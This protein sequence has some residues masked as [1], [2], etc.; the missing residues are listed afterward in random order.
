MF[1]LRFYLNI[2]RISNNLNISVNRFR[3]LAK[4]IRDGTGIIFFVERKLK[5]FSYLTAVGIIGSIHLAFSEPALDNEMNKELILPV[6]R[7]DEVARHY[8]KQTGIWIIHGDGISCAN[9]KWWP[10]NPIFIILL[11]VYMMSPTL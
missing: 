5:K 2:L 8:N 9:K 1:P 6:Y 4:K 3:N 10:L 7:R 11:Q